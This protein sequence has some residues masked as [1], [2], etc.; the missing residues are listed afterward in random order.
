VTFS[1]R[2][3]IGGTE[4]GTIHAAKLFDYVINTDNTN[5]ADFLNTSI[6]A[7]NASGDYIGERYLATTAYKGDWFFI[8]LTTKILLTKYK[9]Y[10][11]STYV[12]MENIWFN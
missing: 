10:G 4:Y 3:T 9:I 5:A 1:N 12:I 11:N 2:F 6:T 8:K 7:Y